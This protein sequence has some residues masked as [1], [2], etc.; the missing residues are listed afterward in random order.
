[1]DRNNEAKLKA[2]LIVAEAMQKPDREGYPKLTEEHP[3]FGRL[4][5]FMADKSHWLGTLQTC[6]TLLTILPRRRI[7]LRSCLTN[8]VSTC[9]SVTVLMYISDGQTERKSSSSIVIG[10][11][12][13]ENSVTDLLTVQE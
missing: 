2:D 11:V 4:R 5:Y 3:F 1:M 7:L 6:L 9:I 8:L 13:N 12:K 10:A